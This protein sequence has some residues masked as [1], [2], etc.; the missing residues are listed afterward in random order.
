MKHYTALKA[1]Q[2]DSENGII[3]SASLMEKGK[4]RGHYDKEGRQVMV[5]DMTL[6]QVFNQCK[7]LG[8]IK[9][10]ADHGSGV[11][12]IVG[13]ADNFS[14]TSNKVTADVHI[15]EAE[16]NRKRLLE[17]AEK[18]PTHMGISM[19][20]T[21]E[22]TAQGKVCMSR[23]DEVLAA[24]LVDDPAAN[25][26]LFSAKEAEQ[27]TTTTKTNNMEEEDKTE[28]TADEK[29][30]ALEEM[31]NELSS[32]FASQFEAEKEEDKTELED[33]ED[34]D[35]SKDEVVEIE[36]EEEDEDDSK[37][38]EMAA[39]RIAEKLFKKFTSS[40]GVT[41]LGRPGVAAEKT[42]EKSFTD[43]VG[44]VAQSEFNGDIVK[45][46]GAILTN[47]SKYPEA[48]KAYAAS[49]NIKHS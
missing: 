47:F 23:C 41:Q 9:V 25:S 21:G 48:S 5:D 36:L 14:L 42:K 27:T 4:A 30:T 2:I 3:R 22:D 44:E 43:L 39:E 46:Q 17:I 33:G 20:F 38:I 34:D 31:V 24:A 26:S 6:E 10:K 28:L 29:I 40:V 19:E 13:W 11:F 49:R 37:K 35:K 32:K 15:Y 1:P 45:A 18:N 7:K 16:T 8:S 12:E